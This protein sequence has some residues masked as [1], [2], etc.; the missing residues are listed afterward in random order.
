[1]KKLACVMLLITCLFGCKHKDMNTTCIYFDFTKHME[2]IHSIDLIKNYKLIPLET[3]DSVIIGKIDKA[4]LYKDR[5]YIATLYST[6]AVYIFNLQGKFL[7]K[8]NNIGRG[9][10]EYLQLSDIFIDQNKQT[11]NLLSRIDAKLLTYDINNLNIIKS[12][13]LPKAFYNMIALK[14]HYLGH[15]GN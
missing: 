12:S 1:M 13:P 14:N 10:E 11:L 8:I 3:N 2:D 5:I 15:V 6:Q 9:P 7:H 4:I